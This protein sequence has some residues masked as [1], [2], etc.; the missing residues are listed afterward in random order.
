MATIAELFEPAAVKGFFNANP[1]N[2]SHEAAASM[3]II[4]QAISLKRI[5]DVLTGGDTYALNQ[6]MEN[7]GEAFALGMRGR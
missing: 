1:E 4:S 6:L 2:M 7:A 3:A 5:A